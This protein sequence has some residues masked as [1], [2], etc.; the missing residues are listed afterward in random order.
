MIY[1]AAFKSHSLFYLQ[2]FVTEHI[3]TP[4]P[5]EPLKKKAVMGSFTDRVIK[6]RSLFPGLP[7]FS[8]L[9][10]AIG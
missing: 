1:I 7:P 6:P 4:Q 3:R 5:K 10:P 8:R 2:K 9:N